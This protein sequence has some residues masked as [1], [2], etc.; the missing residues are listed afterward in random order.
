DGGE[1]GGGMC[2]G[3]LDGEAGVDQIFGGFFVGVDK[4]EM[5]VELRGIAGEITA[6]QGGVGGKD[7][8]GGQSQMGDT[9]DG[10]GGHPLVEVSEDGTIAGELGEADEEFGD[11]E[12][13]SDDFVDFAVVLRGGDA[14]VFPE[15]IFVVVEGTIAAAVVDEDYLGATGDKPATV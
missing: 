10:D 5:V 13:E 1:D 2:G 9:G 3:A 7:G 6:E 15:E 8:G 14:V 4:G 11:G 12:T